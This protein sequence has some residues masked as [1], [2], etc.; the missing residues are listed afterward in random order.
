MAAVTIVIPAYNSQGKLM[1]AVESVQQQDF[2]DWELVVVDDGGSE[3][4]SWVERASDPR[5]RMVRQ[6]NRGVSTAGNVGV[7]IGSAPYVAF[8]D[9]DDEWLPGKLAQQITKLQ[10]LDAT[11][12]FTEFM[13]VSADS[14]WE[15]GP[16]DISYESMLS[17]RQHICLSSVVIARE[18]YQRVGG[19]DPL[20]AQMQDYDLFLRLLLLEERVAYVPD[21][22]VRYT[23]HESD[24]STDYQ[25]A[26]AEALGIVASHRR[27]ASRAGDRVALEA[28]RVALRSRRELFGAKAFDAARVEFRRGRRSTISHLSRAVRL[29][30]GPTLMAM[31]RKAGLAPDDLGQA[32][33]P[34]RGSLKHPR[35]HAAKPRHGLRP[36][37][38]R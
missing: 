25:T 12:S 5:I 36:S 31:A 10:H 26:L 4:L 20:L 32:E 14:A 21:H 13:W 19:R 6:P 18:A 37:A 34:R 27:R 2:V 33:R 35:R 38:A 28:C 15:S 8:L 29:A 30:P 1:R 17:G 7:S 11:F 9:Q 16:S 24:A 22:L 3:D 23:L